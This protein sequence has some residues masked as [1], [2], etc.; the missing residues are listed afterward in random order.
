MDLHLC[1]CCVVCTGTAVPCWLLVVSLHVVHRDSSTVLAAGYEPACCA[2][3]RQH[4]TGCWLCAGMVCTGTAVLYCLWAVCM[5]CAQGQQY[6]TGC[7]LCACMV[8]TGTAVPY[9][10]LVVC[11]HVVHRDSST[12]LAAGCVPAW[13][14]QG[15]QCCTGC[16]LCACMVCTGTAVSYWPLN[17]LV[18]LGLSV[19]M[20]INNLLHPPSCPALCV[21]TVR[22]ALF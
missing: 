16:R 4:H 13:C 3:G 17:V 9:W 7:W 11:L 1:C 8:C 5:Q 12:V 21:V 18:T 14:T 19:A 20:D 6:H 22:T 10:L 15:Q 2:Q